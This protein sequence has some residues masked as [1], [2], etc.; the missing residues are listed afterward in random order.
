MRRRSLPAGRQGFDAVKGRSAPTRARATAGGGGAP[1]CAGGAVTERT[2]APLRGLAL[3]GL[4]AGRPH[5]LL[6]HAVDALDL[7][8]GGEALVEA[9]DAELAHHLRPRGDAADPALHAPLDGLRVVAR[10]LEGDAEHRLDRDRAREHEVGVAPGAAE[11]LRGR[12]EE[13]ADD[14]VALLRGLEQRRAFGEAGGLA[15]GGADVAV[16]L[17]EELGLEDPLRLLAAA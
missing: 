11:H 7:A 13:V 6:L 2:A 3:L 10:Q 12:L 4:D 1:A 5:E 9:L 16:D 8:L 17:V 14:V 15:G